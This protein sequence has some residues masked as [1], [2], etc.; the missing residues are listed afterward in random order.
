[1][2]VSAVPIPCMIKAAVYVVPATLPAQVSLAAA[3][4]LR[5]RGEDRDVGDT[6]ILIKQGNVALHSD[7]PVILGVLRLSVVHARPI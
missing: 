4:F 3:S 5:K 6:E 7:G 1:M 2:V